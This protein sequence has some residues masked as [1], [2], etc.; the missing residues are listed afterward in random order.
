MFARIVLMDP[1]FFYP[2]ENTEVHFCSSECFIR[3]VKEVM[4]DHNSPGVGS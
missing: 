2:G 4:H 3:D 1:L